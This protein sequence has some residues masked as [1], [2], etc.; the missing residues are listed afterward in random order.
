[1][2]GCAESGIDYNGHAALRD[3]YFKQIACLKPFV[4]AYGSAER[5]HCGSADFLQTLAQ[6]GVSLDIGE[7]LEPFTCK[8]LCGTQCLY[9]IRQQIFGVRVYLKFYEIGAEAVAGQPRRKDSFIS[10]AHS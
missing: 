6:Y 2:G 4:G 5:H 7:Y 9:G 10:I 1:M 8:N 3:D